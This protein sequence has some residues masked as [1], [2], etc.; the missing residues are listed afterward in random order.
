MAHHLVHSSI[1]PEADIQNFHPTTRCQTDLRF[2]IEDEQ[3][4]AREVVE[5]PVQSGSPSSSSSRSQQPCGQ[6]RSRSQSPAPARGSPIT[7]PSGT[8]GPQQVSR[9]ESSSSTSGREPG[10]SQSRS[11]VRRS[12]S[13]GPPDMGQGRDDGTRHT[14]RHL[15]PPTPSHDHPCV[16]MFPLVDRVRVRQGEK[17]RRGP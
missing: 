13:A 5:P 16:P 4:T 6:E 1:D 17:L 7:A 8:A 3:K 12:P 11:P 10:H 15:T 9:P 2:H 14:P